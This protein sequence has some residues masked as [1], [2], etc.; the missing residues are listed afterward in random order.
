[1]LISY[2][3]S[4]SKTNPKMMTVED[5]TRERT[6]ELTYETKNKPFVIQGLPM[7]LQFPAITLT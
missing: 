2:F 5:P 1:M 7:L 6:S 4:L 3:D